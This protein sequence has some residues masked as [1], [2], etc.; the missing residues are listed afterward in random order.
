MLF[1]EPRFKVEP[2]DDFFL[3]YRINDTYIDTK[4]KKRLKKRRSP[5]KR[6][7]KKSFNTWTLLWT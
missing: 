4:K 5:R 3:L 2:K 1:L 6:K 7:L